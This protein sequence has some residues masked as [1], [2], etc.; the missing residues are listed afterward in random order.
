MTADISYKELLKK[1]KALEKE[2]AAR[3]KAEA[4]LKKQSEFL[5]IETAIKESETKFRSVA[6]S[7]KD[8]IIT[9]QRC[10]SEIV[11]IQ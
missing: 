6:Q 2:A 11:R 7:A 10:G 8:A 4:Q 9:L 1:V 5:N 3:K